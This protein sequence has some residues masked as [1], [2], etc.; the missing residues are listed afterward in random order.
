MSATQSS[1]SKKEEYPDRSPKIPRMSEISYADLELDSVMKETKPVYTEHG[2]RI[3]VLSPHA[4]DG[5]IGCGGTI[6][7]KLRQG[8][9]VRWI[10]FSNYRIADKSYD[11]V[12]K[13]FMDAMQVLGVTDWALL[14][15]RDTMMEPLIGKIRQ[16]IYDEI[17]NWKPDIIYVPVKTS[18]HED[19]RTISMATQ[20]VVNRRN[21]EVL[22]YPI[23]GDEFNPTEFERLDDEHV[24]KK[25]LAIMCYKS[26]K[27]TRAWFNKQNMM[28]TVTAWASRTPF[29]YVEAFE[30][31]KR[32][33]E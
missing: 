2:D 33:N 8:H 27:K 31:I 1:S 14:D 23:L 32:V 19:H 11:I 18:G 7:K 3:L 22:G 29:K 20:D 28:T 17:N 25:M 15:Y 13:E 5:E 21:I 16:F 24:D 4:D 12:K 10:T 9:K 6:N 26:Q 30:V